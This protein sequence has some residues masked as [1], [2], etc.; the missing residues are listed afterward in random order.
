METYGSVCGQ[1]HSRP[2]VDRHSKNDPPLAY[3]EAGLR[4]PYFRQIGIDAAG[5]GAVFFPFFR[6]G[7]FSFFGRPFLFAR[8]RA[9]LFVVVS[10][11]P[12]F[13]SLF[14]FAGG[15]SVTI[16]GVV[17]R[18]VSPETAGPWRAC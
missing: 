6:A 18:V 15:G 9:A 7:R 10:G 4:L 13:S 14:L 16:A 12:S 11:Y 1:A 5:L 3:A 8:L 2:S 17:I